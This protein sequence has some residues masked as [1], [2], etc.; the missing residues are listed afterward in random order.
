MSPSALVEP[1]TL[2]VAGGLALGKVI[3]VFSSSALANSL[4]LAEIPAN[5]R[6]SHFLGVAL[7]CGIG[8]TMS[9]FIGLLAFADS[10]MLQSGVKLGIIVGSL[11]SGAAGA[12]VLLL[13]PR[14][15]PHLAGGPVEAVQL[16]GTPEQLP[17]SGAHNRH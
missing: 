6:W 14:A 7:L 11:V 16:I 2:G 5:A 10:P 17:M 1:L 4:G 12:L 9:L 8:F 13:T 15:A 3:G